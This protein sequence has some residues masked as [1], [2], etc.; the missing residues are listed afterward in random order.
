[1]P[2]FTIIVPVYN[3]VKTISRTINSILDQDFHDYEIIVQDGMSDDGTLLL[4]K[5]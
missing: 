2:H 3:G 5:K 4:V 1:M